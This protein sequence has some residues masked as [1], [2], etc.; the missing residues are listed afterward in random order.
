MRFVPLIVTNSLHAFAARSSLYTS[1]Q[2]VLNRFSPESYIAGAGQGL[3][4]P[5]AFALLKSN[6]TCKSATMA[7]LSIFVALTN[8]LT[9]R[10]TN[11]LHNNAGLVNALL[12]LLELRG[13][14]VAPDGGPF[15]R[16]VSSHCETHCE[17]HVSARSSGSR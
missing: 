2:L 7:Q 5:M 11:L 15:A 4:A 1:G 6:S 14:E 9:K 16:Y 17:S 12:V 3:L 10:P 13:L 8:S